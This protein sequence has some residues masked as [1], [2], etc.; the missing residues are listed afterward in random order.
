VGF[1]LPTAPQWL[2]TGMDIL[3]SD[4]YNCSWSASMRRRP[5]PHIQPTPL[6][7]DQIGRILE[8]NLSSNRSPIYRCGAGDAER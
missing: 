7:V 1:T 4:H 6:R 3:V 5:N 2:L 8:A